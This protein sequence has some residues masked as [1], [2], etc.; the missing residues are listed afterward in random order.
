MAIWMGRSL[1]KSSGGKITRS[2]GKKRREISREKIPVTIGE[3]RTKRIRVTGGNDKV[4][5]FKAD[6]I[7]VSDPKT[8]K[9]VVTKIKTVT[10]NAANPNYVRRNIMTKGAVVQTDMGKVRLTSRPRQDGT[11]NGILVE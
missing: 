5:I 4:I 1:R 2:S 10:E 3:N 6:T 8:G 7:N 11:L 9:T